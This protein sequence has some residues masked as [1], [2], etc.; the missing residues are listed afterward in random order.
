MLLSSFFV[1]SNVSSGAISR[2]VLVL[3]SSSKLS[4]REDL[5]DPKLMVNRFGSPIL[6]SPGL[7]A[8]VW[9]RLVVGRVSVILFSVMEEACRWLCLSSFFSS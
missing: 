3:C 1:C 4:E 7:K 9:F 8:S 2:M 6:I 5:K